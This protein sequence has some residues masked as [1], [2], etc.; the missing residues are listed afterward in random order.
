MFNPLTLF[1]YPEV[2]H[3]GIAPDCGG[4]FFDDGLMGYL[5]SKY[6]HLTGVDLTKDRESLLILKERV[7]LAKHVLSKEEVTPVL[8]DFPTSI[9]FSFQVNRTSLELINAVS[10]KK[11]IGL[12]NE[13]LAFAYGRGFNV[14]QVPIS[15]AP[16]VVDSD[17]RYL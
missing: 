10:F 12:V 3:E 4:L 1:Q 6:R 7:A 15:Y 2:V 8:F 17:R 16:C 5:L 11:V 14:D 9:P 13:L